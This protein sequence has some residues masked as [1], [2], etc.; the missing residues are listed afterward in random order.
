LERG[1]VKSLTF[2]PEAGTERLR[3]RIHK[4][5]SDQQIIDAAGAISTSKIQ[6]VKLYFMIGL[7]TEI[8][9][10]I[11][12][13]VILVRTIQEILAVSRQRKTITVSVNTFIPKPF[14]PF[15]WS[16][17][18]RES[19]IRRKRRY[20][21]SEFKKIPGVQFTRKSVKDEIL[22]GIFSL[23]DR[24]LAKA[25]YFK[26]QN[27]TDWQTAWQEVGIDADFI[28]RSRNFKNKLP[29]DFIEYGV[30]KE[31]LLGTLGIRHFSNWN[32]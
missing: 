24:E 1:K 3:N 10:D 29:W 19:E 31:R 27:N 2:A 11:E 30:P 25:I 12:A 7:P 20:L 4:N 9:E 18:E 28:H 13:I 15:Q 8:D 14:T 32:N 22:Q 23:G 17:M 26:I 6:Q 21:E 16:P 5:L